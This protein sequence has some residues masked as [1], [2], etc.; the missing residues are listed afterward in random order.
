[1]KE[2]EIT[3]RYL[4]IDDVLHDSM[5]LEGMEPGSLTGRKDKALKSLGIEHT[6]DAHLKSW[7]RAMSEENDVEYTMP[8]HPG[9]A[10]AIMGAPAAQ[11]FMFWLA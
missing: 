1:M 3:I 11:R 4:D 9:I 6:E 7:I 5:V 10:D 2:Q 8:S